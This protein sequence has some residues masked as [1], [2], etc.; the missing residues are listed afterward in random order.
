MRAFSYHSTVLALLIVLA[1][2]TYAQDPSSSPS[3]SQTASP[4]ASQGPSS[5]SSSNTASVTGSA[6]G[7]GSASGNA[8]TV[9]PSRTTIVTYS[10]SFAQTRRFEKSQI[11]HVLCRFPSC[12]ERRMPRYHTPP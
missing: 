12:R 3:A 7:A 2:L 6:S 4:S 10:V 11:A 1:S 8:T 9:A 5:G